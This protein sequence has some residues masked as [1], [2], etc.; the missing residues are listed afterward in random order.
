MA[1]VKVLAVTAAL[2][3][4]TSAQQSS[5]VTPTAAPSNSTEPTLPYTPG[6]D[7]SAMDRTVDPC[8]DFYQYSCGGWMKSHPIPPD[9]TSWSVYGKLYEDNLTYLRGI[10][11]E[12][13]AVPNRD[14][15]TQKIGDYYAA[16]MD[17]STVEKLGDQPL[18]PDLSAIDSLKTT[19]D[20]AALIATLHSQGIFPLFLAGSQQDPDNSDAV[21]VAVAQGGLG[22]PDRDY[23][24][25]DD[26]KSREIRERYVKHVEKIFELIGD[27][28]QDA[29]TNA[30]VV[31]RIETSLAQASLTR[32][33]RR[34]PY[35]TK[36][37]MT[38]PD[39][40]K[41]A[42]DFDWKAYF[43]GRSGP[44]FQILNVG[45]PDFF[46]DVDA[47]LKSVPLADWKSYIRFHVANSEA[48]YLSSA[49]VAENLT[50]TAST[51]AEPWSSS[52][53]GSAASDTSTT[54][55]ERHWDR[56]MSARPSHPS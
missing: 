20:L 43:A 38:V 14:A 18:Q 24:L 13:A 11:D 17:E 53:A 8:V 36:H 56:L 40:Y 21:I 31:M 55:L 52:L 46:K 16:C 30:A 19:K 10:L 9:Q 29:N 15:V 6:L 48:A 23:Y 41:I 42:P 47:Q 49:F 25:K 34:D 39:L 37:K 33:Q 5:R 4:C 1:L 12:A 26:A 7:P 3:I 27:S 2:A 45:W 28:P 51:S 44:S 50:S 35:K 32:V 22:L 54:I